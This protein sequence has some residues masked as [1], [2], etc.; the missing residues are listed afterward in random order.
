MYIF[1]NF[2]IDGKCFFSSSSNLSPII[3]LL[4]KKKGNER[5]EGREK[6]DKCI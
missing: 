2:I 4:K 1:F 6:N 5:E 3:S